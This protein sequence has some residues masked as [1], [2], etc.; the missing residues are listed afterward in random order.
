MTVQTARAHGGAQFQRRLEGDEFDLQPRLLVKTV[1]L[2]DVEHD[3][4]RGGER[5]DPERLGR[6]AQGEQNGRRADHSRERLD[7]KT[8]GGSGLEDLA[9]HGGTGSEKALGLNVERWVQ[10]W[11]F[12]I[13][14]RVTVFG[15]SASAPDS[16]GGSGAGSGGGCDVG[17]GVGRGVG[18][19]VR[20]HPPGVFR[21]PRHPNRLWSRGCG[22]VASAP[23]L[24][25]FFA[26]V[27]GRS[28]SVK[29]ADRSRVHKGLRRRSYQ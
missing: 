8:G 16:G 20:E 9:A 1:V 24:L 7:G 18:H 28:S 14:L 15:G 6:S 23:L 5:P 12:E 27:F 10:R 17:H 29:T 2:R 22:P 3:R 19:G 26:S 4:V 21:P 25:L 11:I 13:V